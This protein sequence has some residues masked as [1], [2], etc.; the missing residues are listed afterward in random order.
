MF[1][2]ITAVPFTFMFLTFPSIRYEF[3]FDQTAISYFG[4][5]IPWNSNNPGLS[6]YKD[7]YLIPLIINI[8]IIAALGFYL[9]R[10]V[11]MLTRKAELAVHI[12]IYGLGLISFI[13]L[14][15]VFMTSTCSVTLM[16]ETWPNKL[17]SLG[18][19]LGM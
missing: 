8:T 16:P 1:K 19:S 4:T 7:I 15:T 9:I 12:L 18:L 2:H 11:S 10:T 6:L 13:V 17:L 5:P 14:L 3:L